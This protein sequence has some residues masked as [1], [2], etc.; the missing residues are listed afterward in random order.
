[1]ARTINKVRKKATPPMPPLTLGRPPPRERGPP[2]KAIRKSK[3]TAPEVVSFKSMAACM[4][5]AILKCQQYKRAKAKNG[6]G[7]KRVKLT[8]AEKAARKENR[9]IA[10]EEKKQQKAAER[11]AKQAARV[12]LNP[13]KYKKEKGFWTKD[14]KAARKAKWDAGYDGRIERKFMKA[15]KAKLKEVQYATAGPAVHF[16]MYISFKLITF[17]I[18]DMIHG[19]ELAAHYKK[20]PPYKNPFKP[21][22]DEINKV[23][24]NDE[25]GKAS[26][27]KMLSQ[28]SI[29]NQNPFEQELPIKWNNPNNMER[30]INPVL[31][32]GAHKKTPV[33]D[34]DGHILGYNIQYR[35]NASSKQTQLAFGPNQG[36]VMNTSKRG[37]GL[38]TSTDPVVFT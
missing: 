30:N 21:T 9:R 19:R 13:G 18:A 28:S 32:P 27:L 17:F 10:S 4:A 36:K 20:H 37:K 35:K 5:E 6:T 22:K 38:G 1:M 11:L 34:A 29:P 16:N 26:F 8:E 7:V 24:A 23:Y 14:A 3:V 2:V 12:I 31:Q 15:Q 25:K 33:T